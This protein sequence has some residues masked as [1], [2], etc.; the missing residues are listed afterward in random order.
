[1]EGRYMKSSNQKRKRRGW[2]AERSVK[3]KVNLRK[4]PK[5]Y[6]PK[7]KRQLFKDPES[8]RR[9]AF[10]QLLENGGLLMLTTLGR[11]LGSAGVYIAGN[12][13]RKREP[14]LACL[15]EVEHPIA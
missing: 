12:V 3:R 14:Y 15:Q 10:A 5:A 9:R 6:K 7:A 11:S 4:K 8:Q 1:M 13:L 2:T